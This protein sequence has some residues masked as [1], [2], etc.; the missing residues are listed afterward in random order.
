MKIHLI[1]HAQSVGNATN[2]YLS[3]EIH[4]NLSEAGHIQ[5]ELL[6]SALQEI[7]FDYLYCSPLMRALQTIY[8]YAKSNNIKVE[9]WP[10]LAE[11]CWQEDQLIKNE[12]CFRSEECEAL[13]NFR[14]D[15]FSFRDANAIMPVADESY[16]EGIYRAN[17]VIQ[18]LNETHSQEDPTI[19][20]VGHGHMNS[21]LIEILLGLEPAGRIEFDNTGISFLHKING[22][23]RVRYINRVNHLSQQREQLNHA[24]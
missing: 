8:P 13:N 24:K 2:N 15:V 20:I 14:E 5:A 1:R 7:P 10:E 3:S 9:V 18:L 12:K 4:D 16:S 6:I 23:C 19:G 17:K 21:R 22:S 11:G